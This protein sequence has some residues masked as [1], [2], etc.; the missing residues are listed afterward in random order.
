[1]SS[2]L[3]LQLL[4]SAWDTAAPDTVAMT[5]MFITVNRNL[6]TPVF[7]PR[8]YRH[9]V[10]EFE[11]VGTVVLAVTASDDDVT[12]PENTIIFSIDIVNSPGSD[13]F[14][15]HPFSG[16]IAIKRDLADDTTYPSEYTV[17]KQFGK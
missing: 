7:T 13:Y 15:I 14:T 11:P 4:V 1:V 10:N 2:N 16:A 3:S 8:N 17:S 5:T 12:V 6:F 9:V